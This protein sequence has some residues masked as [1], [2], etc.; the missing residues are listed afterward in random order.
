LL[1]INATLYGK[2]KTHKLHIHAAANL[3]KG[4]GVS[5][6]L[7]DIDLKAGKGNAILATNMSDMVDSIA[8]LFTGPTT[9]ATFESQYIHIAFG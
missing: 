8:C 3:E 6:G 7:F 9:G 2:L 5:R 4:H 1:N